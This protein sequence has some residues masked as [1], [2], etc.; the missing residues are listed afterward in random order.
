MQATKHLIPCCSELSAADYWAISS[1]QCGWHT[2]EQSGVKQRGWSNIEWRLELIKETN[3]ISITMHN[4]TISIYTI[5]VCT[6]LRSHASPHTYPHP[7]PCPL[8]Q[9][10]PVLAHNPTHISILSHP[11]PHFS[12]QH[13]PHGDD[14]SPLSSA[15]SFNGPPPPSLVRRKPGMTARTFIPPVLS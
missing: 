5:D 10:M 6:V 2:R 3:I 7:V 1:S 11:Q 9:H 15:I 12:E 4:S 13:L 8:P 14:A